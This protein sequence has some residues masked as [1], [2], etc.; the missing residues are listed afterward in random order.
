MHRAIGFYQD[1]MDYVIKF[2]VFRISPHNIDEDD[3]DCG[4]SGERSEDTEFL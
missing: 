2:D 1:K 3:I 4:K